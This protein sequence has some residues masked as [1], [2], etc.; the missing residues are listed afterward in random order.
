MSKKELYTK[1]KELGYNGPLN[2]RGSTAAQWRQICNEL[3]KEPEYTEGKYTF[4]LQALFNNDIIKNILLPKFAKHEKTVLRFVVRG[5]A[6]QKHPT[7]NTYKWAKRGQLNILK[8]AHDQ[9]CRIDMF[10][11]AGA[12]KRGHPEIAE[13][14]RSLKVRIKDDMIDYAARGGCKDF[15]QHQIRN[16]NKI[17]TRFNAVAK[18]IKGG[19]T[20]LA[21]WL[22][23]RGFK[24]KK[25]AFY[26]AARKSDLKMLEKL[27]KHKGEMSNEALLG[28]VE[29]G[30]MNIVQWVNEKLQWRTDASNTLALAVAGGNLSIVK[31]CVKRN[32][33]RTKYAFDIAAKKGRLDIIEYL[34]E[35]GCE[36]R[37][38]AHVYAAK[39]KHHHITRWLIEN[40]PKK[41]PLDVEV[42]R[43][44]VLMYSVDT[45]EY[46]KSYNCPW[47]PTV[48]ISPV[49][50]KKKEKILQL[51]ALG[52]PFDILVALKTSANDEMREWLVSLGWQK[53]PPLYMVPKPRCFD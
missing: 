14:A 39:N 35:V 25:D 3:E 10:T 6:K 44:A 21:H 53:A 9:D 29:T 28:A 11:V 5:I 15:I 22:L 36:M 43:D 30:K 33:A 42:F 27:E 45:W 23:E 18:A 46:L 38:R 1:A 41:C 40:E 19:H 26:E 2:W 13:W 48:Y 4:D 49:A 7:L 20:E 50:G 16:K 24:P 17:P 32:A 52:C 8:W 47:D 31:W 37:S 12:L 34:S 51:H